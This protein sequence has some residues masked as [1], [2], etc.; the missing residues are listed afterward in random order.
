[1]SCFQGDPMIAG[2]YSRANADVEN[3]EKGIDG[4]C[5]RWELE[6]RDVF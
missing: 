1:M 3:N 4:M 5:L 2:S 6:S